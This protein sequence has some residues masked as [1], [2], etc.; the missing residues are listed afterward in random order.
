MERENPRWMLNLYESLLSPSPVIPTTKIPRPWET[1][2]GN[3]KGSPTLIC[4]RHTPPVPANPSI[5][6]DPSPSQSE[7]KN[8]PGPRI[9]GQRPG[10]KIIGTQDF[11]YAPNTF[12]IR[13]MRKKKFVYSQCRTDRV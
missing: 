2:T 6:R 10:Q 1:Q 13:A 11:P 3:Q 8:S 5:F 9:P 4:I 7:Y 12:R